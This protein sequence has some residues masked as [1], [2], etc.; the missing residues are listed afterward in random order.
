MARRKTSRVQHSGLSA[1]KSQTDI[2]E[3]VLDPISEEEEA[4]EDLPKDLSGFGNLRDLI[5]LGRLEADVKIGDF[6]FK[7]STL[8]SLQQKEIVRVLM[9]F[10]DNQRMANVRDYTLAQCIDSIN[11]MPL[12]DLCDSNGA[13]TLG[14]KVSALSNLQN[15]VL[16]RLFLKYNDLVT[17]DDDEERSEEALK[18]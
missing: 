11:G 6:L 15:S 5:F 17:E 1:D 2:E 13:T 16:D 7:I 4:A 9:A 18:K 8:S 12:D 10:D 3:N 14:D